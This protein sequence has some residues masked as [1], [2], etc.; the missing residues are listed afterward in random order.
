M[1]SSPRSMAG[2]SEYRGHLTALLCFADSLF[3][4]LY[5]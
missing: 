5:L 4:R 3:Y 1:L 2:D